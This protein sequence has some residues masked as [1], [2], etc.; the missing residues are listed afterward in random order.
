M[1]LLGGETLSAYGAA[2]LHAKT[3][4]AE[5]TCTLALQLQSPSWVGAAPAVTTLAYIA[6][7][8]CLHRQP[9]LP[10]TQS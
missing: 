9:Y 5:R 3:D 1:P 10:F 7:H 2:A 4:T 8:T 6:N